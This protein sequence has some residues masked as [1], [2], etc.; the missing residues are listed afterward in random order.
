VVEGGSELAGAVPRA[1][2]IGADR[3]SPRRARDRVYESLQGAPLA[4]VLTDEDEYDLLLSASEMVNA[5]LLAGA[6]R[7]T[8]ELTLDDRRIRIAVLDDTPVAAGNSPSDRA[9]RECLRVVASVAHQWR[10]EPTSTGR[11]TL[12][13][14]DFAG[15]R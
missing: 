14:F 15:R 5:G 8:L 6:R 2:E 4:A 12:A 9:Q 11:T 3:W 7:M 13:D 10:T 1:F